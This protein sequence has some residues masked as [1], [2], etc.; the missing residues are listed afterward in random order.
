MLWVGFSCLRMVICVI[1]EVNFLT[2]LRERILPVGVTGMTH[3]CTTVRTVRCPMCMG[4][5][6]VM[7]RDVNANS[8]PKR[9]VP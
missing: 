5:D 6:H 9:C 4:G 8:M 7:L 3:G 1:K 2:N